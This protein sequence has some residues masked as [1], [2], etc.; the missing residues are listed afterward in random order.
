MVFNSLV[1]FGFFLVFFTLYW[2]LSKQKVLFQNLLLLLGSYVFY[3]W[4]DWRFLSLLIGVSLL[5]FYLGIKISKEINDRYKRLYVYIGL[6]QGIGGLFYFKYFNFFI[7]SFKQSLAYFGM[8]VNVAALDI[9]VPLGISFFTFRTISYLLDVD[10]GKIKASTDWVVFFNY[11]SFFPT[12]LSGPIDKGRE[13]IPQLEK[14][15]AF[16]YE[17]AIDGLKQILW[18]LFKK[19]VIADNCALVVN[20]IFAS[21]DVMPSSSLWLGMFFYSIQIYADFSGYSDMAIGVSKLLG[22]KVTKNF[23]YPFFSQ[24]IPEY[25]RKWHISLTSWLTEYIFT[26]LSIFFRDYDK[27]G[28]ILAIVINFVI[29]GIW[30]GANWTY[31]LFG[32]VHGLYFIP[33]ILKGTINKKKKTD[34]TKALPSFKEFLNMISTFIPVMFTFVLFKSATVTHAFLYYG[35]MFTKTI[36]SAP[37]TFPLYIA[38]FVGL[39]ILLEWSGRSQDYAMK[40]TFSKFPKVFQVLFY[41]ILLATIFVFSA[42][43][44]QFIYFQF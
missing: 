13:F 5:N 44:Q 31:V 8:N 40:K 38:G 36:I 21:F 20:P 14:E 26:P 37:A 16:D 18:G 6:I 32:L 33:S 11:V 27:M 17:T 4:T 15:R 43:E 24:S 3:A 12:L 10:K 7:S 19:L 2:S 35:K 29:C 30:H 23:D 22:F 1:F 25:W 34:L 28:L 41:F 9:I 39:F 42:K